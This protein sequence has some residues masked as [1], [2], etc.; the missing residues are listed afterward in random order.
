MREYNEYRIEI[1][2]YSFLL[3]KLYSINDLEHF[4]SFLDERIG[5]LN[6]RIGGSIEYS[7]VN[8]VKRVV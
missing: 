8:K 7:T 3:T 4:L 5:N 2:E 1:D 6:K